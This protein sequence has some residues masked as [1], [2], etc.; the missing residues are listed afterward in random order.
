MPN[1][2]LLK[3]YCRNS[4]S[5]MSWQKF[6]RIPCGYDTEIWNEYLYFLMDFFEMY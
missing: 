4:F 2:D 3:K 1:L 6:E 5:I